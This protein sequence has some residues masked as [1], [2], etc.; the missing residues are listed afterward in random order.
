MP[1]PKF[2]GIRRGDLRSPAGEHSSPLHISPNILMR[3][4]LIQYVFLYDENIIIP[5]FCITDVF[6]IKKVTE[7]II[8][9]FWEA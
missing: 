9:L 7:K 4:S 8:F 5:A 6:F 2:M 3:T 1:L